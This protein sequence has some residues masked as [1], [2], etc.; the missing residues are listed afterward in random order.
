MPPAPVA[1]L[2]VHADWS[3]DPRKRWMSV[4]TPDG[5]IWRVAVPEPVGPPATLLARLLARGGGGAVALGIDCPIGVPRA[6]GALQPEADFPA[7]LR[8]RAAP[9]YSVAAVLDDVHPGAPFYPARGARGMT[10]QAHAVALGLQGAAALCRACD[11]ATAE[12]P[13]GA[14]VFWTLGANQ[15]GKAA[16]SAWRDMLQP[17]LAGPAPP[18]LWPFEGNFRAL[19]APG[20][21]AVAETYPAEAMRHLGLRPRGSKR[22]QADRAA[23]RPALAAAMAACG[24]VPDEALTAAMASGFGAAPAGEDQFDSLLGVLCVIG[25]LRGA[26]PDSAP[27]DPAIRRWEGWVLG[28]TALPRAAVCPP[29]P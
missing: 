15:S 23:Y 13:A 17:A 22:R 10:R 19:L 20:R 14:P 6:Y 8:S 3:T 12:R 28:Q 5:D 27:E 7:F 11:R 16:I 18:R 1:A 4:A 9:F 26:R 25:V 2:A 29:Q 21:V 24:A